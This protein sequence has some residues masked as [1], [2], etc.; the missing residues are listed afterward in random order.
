MY[1]N[2]DYLLA[3]A[4]LIIDIMPISIVFSF[5][6]IFISLLLSLVFLP[7]TAFKIKWKN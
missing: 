1:F 5:I 6:L 3:I 7:F 4:Y 2:L